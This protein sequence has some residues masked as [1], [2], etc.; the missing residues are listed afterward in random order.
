MAMLYSA[1]MLSLVGPANMPIGLQS[2]DEAAE[3]AAADT[4]ITLDEGKVERISPVEL[5]VY[6]DLYGVDTPLPESWAFLTIRGTDYSPQ[7]YLAKE[8]GPV[9]FRIAV[10]AQGNATGC[11]VT[12]SSGFARLDE[13][14]CPVL[15]GRV[16]K[17][18][19]A[20]DANGEAVAAYFADE[21]DW[22]IREPELTNF[23]AKVLFVI[24]PTGNMERCEILEA[25]GDLPAD[26]SPSSLCDGPLT[27]DGTIYRDEQ[28]MPTRKRVTME[29]RVQSE[30][31]AG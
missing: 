23:V 17:F 6:G 30:D 29:F 3:A 13:A 16:P 5:S 22:K 28:G 31:V 1:I 25:K 12:S 26:Y 27:S 18:E 10:D 2:V 9:G 24:G 15:M 4:G 8:E 11:E 20:I 14:T 7:S 21:A 19:P